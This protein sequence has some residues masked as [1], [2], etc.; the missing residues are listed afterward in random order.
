MSDND[1]TTILVTQGTR[2]RINRIKGG[3]D[4][5]QEEVINMGLDLL[6]NP[7]RDLELDLDASKVNVNEEGGKVHIT[8]E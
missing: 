5:T 4:V 1:R 6:E 8:V 7:E 3:R 2:R